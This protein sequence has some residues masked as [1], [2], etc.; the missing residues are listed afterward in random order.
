[1][2]RDEASEQIALAEGARTVHDPWIHANDWYAAAYRFVCDGIGQGLRALIVVRV[3]RRGLAVRRQREE[4]RRVDDALHTRGGGRGDHVSQ[5]AD[6][7]VVEVLTPAAPDADEC[8]GMNEGVASCCGTLECDAIA[9]VAV[10]RRAG[11]AGAARRSGEQDEIVM[12]A[13]E[14]AGNRLPE[15]A[16]AARQEDLHQRSVLSV[17][18]P[19]LQQV[20]DR[21]V[22]WNLRRPAE[23]LA[24]RG[25]IA[26]EERR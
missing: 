19:V 13:G 22:H 16:G 8:R 7:D 3:K 6:V 23:A 11:P 5:P 24:D 18:A 4:R 9:D 10:E 26:Q 20:V 17:S 15:I 2:I 25:R 14:R 12:A 21:P 1:M